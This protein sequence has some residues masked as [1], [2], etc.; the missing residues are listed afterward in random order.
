MAY[1]SRQSPDDRSMCPGVDFITSAADF[2]CETSAKVADIGRF[3][4]AVRSYSIILS[5]LVANL[6]ANTASM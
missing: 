5:A 3:D 2:F 1:W 6:A 4:I